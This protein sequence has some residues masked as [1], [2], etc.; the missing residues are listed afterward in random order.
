[1]GASDYV[2]SADLSGKRFVLHFADNGVN[3]DLTQFFAG[4]DEGTS[5]EESRKFIASEQGFRHQCVSWDTRPI[6]VSQDGI[7]HVLGKTSLFQKIRSNLRMFRR[8]G[9]FFVVKVMKQTDKTPLLFVLAEFA[10]VKPHRCLN[11][12]QVLS[13]VLVLN[14]F[15]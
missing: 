11:C 5:D 15:A 13:H 2:F 1:L 4:H 7:H 6:G 10:G 14:P 3:P 8:V 9:M 12:Q